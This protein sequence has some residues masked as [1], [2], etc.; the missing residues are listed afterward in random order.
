M[1]VASWL[2]KLGFAGCLVRKI[3]PKLGRFQC[4][5]VRRQGFDCVLRQPDTT[6]ED[7]GQ[8]LRRDWLG[9]VLI[10][11]RTE[12]SKAGSLECVRRHRD[13][14][15]EGPRRAAGFPLYAP[16]IVAVTLEMIEL[17][18]RSRPWY[19]MHTATAIAAIISAY[20]GSSSDWNLL[21]RVVSVRSIRFTQVQSAPVMPEH[22][23]SESWIKLPEQ[24]G[25]C[26]SDPALVAVR[27]TGWR[28]GIA[29]RCIIQRLASTQL[30]EAQ[31]SRGQQ[32]KR[33]Q[34]GA[35][36]LAA[37]ARG[38]RID[39]GHV[40]AKGHRGRTLITLLLRRVAAHIRA[41]SSSSYHLTNA[42]CDRAH[43]FPFSTWS[44]PVLNDFTRPCAYPHS[45]R[46]T[47]DPPSLNSR[48]D[49]QSLQSGFLACHLRTLFNSGGR[50]SKCRQNLNPT[51]KEMS[52]LLFRVGK[53]LPR[54]TP[55]RLPAPPS[56][57]SPTRPRSWLESG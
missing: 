19:A 44:H 11:A 31:A 41:W 46:P 52:V 5:L 17:I 49:H 6:L 21:L 42:S 4:A 32:C 25:S 22:T 14:Y 26:E 40:V 10:H 30:F 55:S 18:A 15:V 13:Y 51:D 1:G 38:R 56:W 20:S 34:V 28:V 37:E 45:L 12:A 9:D 48:G 2:K 57:R 3:G 27:Y 50:W 24:I 47:L 39:R 23:P 33:A 54:R 35:T 36:G 8:R 43:G 16:F 53:A 7:S 29:S